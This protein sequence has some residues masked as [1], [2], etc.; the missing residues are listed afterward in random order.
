MKRILWLAMMLIGLGKAGYAAQILVSSDITVS[1][2]WTA[3][4][5]YNLQNQIYVKPGATLTIEAGTVIASTTG[6][7]GSLAVCRGG[8]IYV[9]G[10]ACSPVIM[11]SSTDVATWAADASH[12]TGHNPKTGTWHEGCNEWGN[13]TV[14]GKGLISASMFGGLP[15]SV[16]TDDDCTAGGSTTVRVNTSVPDGLNQKQMEGLT[17]AYTGDCNVLYGGNDDNDNSGAIHYLSLRYGG[18]VLGLGNELNGLSMGAIGRETD[19]DHV[20]I[21]NNVD[22]GIET[23][24]GTVNYKYL[25]IWNA[26][27]DGFDVDEGWRGK[28]QFGL[29]VEGYSTNAARGSGV[30]DNCFEVDGAED[31]DAQPVTTATIYNFTAVGQPLSARGGTAWRDNARVQYR[32]CIFM[33][34]GGQLIKFDNSDGDGANG[35]GYNG[36]LS[37]ANTWTT[38][39]TDHSAVNAGSWSPGA[40]N[41][42][43]VLY[44]A[45]SSGFLAEMTDCVFYNNLGATAGGTPYAESDNRGVTIS[46][47][48][49]AALHN[50]V[51]TSSPIQ[52]LTRG[53]AVVKG[54]LT[55]I[56]V[57]NINPLPANDAL[58]SFAAAPADGFFTPAM[59][60]G[61]FSPSEDWLLGWTAADAYG[62]VTP[63]TFATAT[64]ILVSSDISVST[65]WTADNTYNLQNQIYVK[66]GAT[67]TIEAGTVIASTTGG[68]GSLAVCRGG[69]IYVNGT[70]CSP[71][72][73]TSST[74]VATWAADASHPT[75]HNPKTGTWHEGCNEWGNLTVMGKGLISASMFGG[76]PVSV[77]TDDDCTAGGSTTVRVNTSVPDG[78]NQKQMEGLTAA[79]TGDCNVL[80][81]GN[82]DNDN[83]GAI[84]Y[85]SLRYGGKV[86]GLG[87]ELN[88]LSMG[89][90]GRETD[91]DH[92]EIM[93]NVDD[94]IETWGGTVNYKYL[95]IW[96]AGDDGFDVDEGWR[97]KAQFGLIVEGYSTNA[98]RGSGVSDNCFEVDGAEDSDA[99]PVTTATIYN[100]TAVGQ[101]LSAR[102]GTAWRDNARV[103]YRNCIFMELGGQLIKF[104]NSD[105]DGANGYGYNGTLSWANTWTTAYT[106]H[107]AVNAGSWSPGAFNDPA[108]LYQAQSSGFLAEMTDCVFY[109]NLGA[110]AGGTPYAESDNRGVTISGGSNA[111]LHNV[112]ATSSPIQS[113]TRG[114]AV[115]KGGLTVIP[116]TNINPLPANDAL[117]SFA[118][119]PADGFFTPAMYRG[120]FSPSEDWLLGWTAA[121][122][123]GMVCTVPPSNDATVTSHTVPAQLLVNQGLTVGFYVRNDGGTTWSP[124]AFYSFKVT[125]DSCNLFSGAAQLNMVP[126]QVTYPGQTYIF[127]GV[128]QAPA[129]PSA[130]C[131]LRLE[132]QENST[133]FGTP[134]IL[135][136]DIVTPT[137]TPT[138][139]A[140]RD[141]LLYQ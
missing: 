77:T 37:W 131:S 32:N 52:S 56:P 71:V 60:R 22:D 79:Y 47:G 76:L 111:A 93:N 110:T 86:L 21:M 135:S 114:P 26:G 51:A 81:G 4:N 59:Y 115:V 28:A 96:N 140:V 139:N 123:Y 87:N 18:K 120:A 53:P 25:T 113:L 57:T 54:G 117:A 116:V 98:A 105:G 43:A 15:V 95:T 134:L 104:D 138:A 48:S 129:V 106:D 83:S 33:E 35:Y 92:V 94:G 65:T 112:V 132:M 41:D 72:I 55:V 1:T 78:L 30:S 141:W 122:A 27:D 118:A 14:M 45:Q 10:T 46:G 75:G 74:D 7:G 64:P 124:E 66:P 99:Q 19:V 16:T 121:D 29:I 13:L 42:P 80:Y 3:D 11:T 50:V 119:A 62:M 23:W 69:K 126:G 36:T 89:A 91:V 82:D 73:M 108:V 38:A 6:G 107:S 39:Y 101:P 44:Q 109:N 127:S 31:S 128:L 97:G 63:P 9:N 85:L 125:T 24:G 49:N 12:P 8:K 103:Q 100:F 2:T 84:H 34:L 133:T 130:G 58:A 102:G 20:E 90:I 68:G 17:A 61:A 67:L 136:V 70:A 40:F 137:P 88:G 5:T